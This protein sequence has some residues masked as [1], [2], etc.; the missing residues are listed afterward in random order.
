MAIT[1]LRIHGV[2]GSPGAAALGVPAADTPT[3]YRGRRTRVLARRS[4]PSVQAYDWGR[5]TTDSPLQPLWVL[6]LPF[7]L[8]NVSGWAHGHFPGG[9]A[10]IQLTRALVHLGAVLLT[11]GYVL[12]AA[13][14]GIDYL[15]YQALGRINDA[16]QLAGVLTGFLLTAAVPVVLLIIADATRRRYER[17]DPGHGVG[18]RD[19]TARWQPAEDLSSEQ[20]FAHD[21]S[22][23]KLLGWHSAV[24]ALTLGGVAVLTVTNWGGANLGLG[25]LFLGIG[26]AQILVAVLLA[27]ACWAPGGQF[28]GQ[29]GALA[30]PASAVTMAAAL[31]NG[32][33]AGF[34]LLAAQLSGIRWDRWGQELALIEAFV[35][36]LLAWAAALGIWILRRRGRGNADELPSRTTPEGQPPDGVTEELREQ[37]ATA[38]GNAE[39]AKSAPQLVTVFAGLFLASSLAVLLLRLDTSAAVA[40]W[41]RPPEPGVLS[42]AAAVLLP[43][44]ALGAVWL[45]WHSSRKRALRRTVAA[46]WDVLT[47][48]PRR[49]HP[50]A[51]RPFTERAVPEFQRLITERIRS[52][53]GLIVSA[54]S[55]GSALAFAALA[56]MGSAMLHRCGLLTYGSPITT[57]YGQ[58]FP[59]YFGQAGVDQLRLRLASGR[60]GWA[61]HYRLTDPIGGPVIGSGDPAVD[62]QLPDPAEAASFPVPADDPEPLRPVWADVA[63]HQLYRREAAYKEAVRRFRARLG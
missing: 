12:W 62:L 5:L 26:L 55:Q 18:T 4:N 15:G 44:V 3:L 49:Y 28:P 34:A 36:T 16:A 1:E 48:W 24:I 40:D 58:A 14:I 27:A 32:F 6:L 60:G 33:C 8:I 51:V 59:A 45:V 10:R 35:I 46:V 2:G 17:V 11:A 57:L 61:N 19:G 38:R 25:R 30:L 52:D 43:A 7:T 63:G 47:F 21:R 22:L 20:F 29:P 56:P 9:L 41:I 53:G 31:G 23:K 42:W 13:I 39:A 50:F 54:H 37:V